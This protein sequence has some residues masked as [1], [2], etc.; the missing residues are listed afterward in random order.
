MSLADRIVVMEQGHIRQVGTPAEVYDRPAHLF[1][2]KFVGSPGMNLV[3]CRLEET[4]GVL[5]FVTEPGDVRLNLP[6]DGARGPVTTLTPTLGIRCEHLHEQPDGPIRGRVLTEEYLGNARIVHLE[7]EWGRL[8]VR[9]DVA[10]ARVVGSEL[11][12]G[13]DP[14][15]VSVFDRTS[16]SRV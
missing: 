16:D 12:L 9:T 3:P 4:N 1:V 8:I 7:T 13:F 10:K 6:L 2:A 5:Q 11:R 14:S 15:Q